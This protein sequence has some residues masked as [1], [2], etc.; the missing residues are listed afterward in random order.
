MLRKMRWM[1]MMLR[2]MRVEDA[3]VEDDDVKG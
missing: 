2:K 3:E 1:I